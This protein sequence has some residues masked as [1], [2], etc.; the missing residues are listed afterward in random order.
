LKVIHIPGH[1]R[2]AVDKRSGGEESVT[3]GARV[4]Y[5]ESSA[6]LGNSSIN[7]KDA[8]IERWQNMAIHPGAQNSALFPVTPFDKKDSDFQFQYRDRG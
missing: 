5:V 2:H 1:N 7:R 3:I 8:T 4:G 6:P